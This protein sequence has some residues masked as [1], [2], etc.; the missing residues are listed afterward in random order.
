MSNH[1]TLTT[2]ALLTTSI[3]YG[4]AIAAANQTSYQLSSPSGCPTTSL[5][6]SLSQEQINNIAKIIPGRNSIKITY[7]ISNPTNPRQNFTTSFVWETLP[8]SQYPV[9]WHSNSATPNLK[10]GNKDYQIEQ[11]ALLG[12][13]LTEASQW[14]VG[15]RL[16]SSCLYLTDNWPSSVDP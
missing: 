10:L 13:S 15:I 5:T 7:D 4:N 3:I 12:T 1:R 11:I 8:T 9:Q 16:S 2:I 14:H 6:L